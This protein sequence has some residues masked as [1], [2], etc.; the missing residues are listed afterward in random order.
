MKKNKDVLFLCQFFYPE[1]ISSAQLPFDTAK[2]LA[3]AGYSVNA[4]CGFPKEYSDQKSEKKELVEGIEIER[5]HYLQLPRTN[6]F[7]RLINYFSFTSSV[8]LNFWKLK[9]FKMIIVYSNPPILP[10]IAVL[11]KKLFST[12]FIFI[13]YDVYPE[14]ALAT[15][16]LNEGGIIT[17][18]MRLLNKSIYKNVKKIVALSN[19][20]KEFLLKNRK[21]SE[22]DVVVIPNWHKDT[23]EQQQSSSIKSELFNNKLYSD[24]LVISYMGNMGIAQDMQTI[25][26]AM[27]RLK[28]ESR[29]QFLIAGHGNKKES[30]AAY[31]KN[32][33]IKN[34]EIFEYLQGTDFVAANQVSDCFIV[35][36]NQDST[37]L[38]VPSKT[39]SY[40]MAG[41]P[42]LSI[43]N[44]KSDISIELEKNNAGFAIEN[45]GVASF[46]KAVNE[47][48]EQPNL[49]N[50]MG[51]N[52]RQLY[53][54]NYTEEK[55]AK[56][57]TKLISQLIGDGSHVQR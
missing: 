21:I 24:K 46:V 51:Q 40:L 43:M 53:L 49:V 48:L 19:D 37:G 32:H 6:F 27:E 17:K 1:Y 33:Q 9:K 26:E 23:Y 57:Y 47:L 18:I 42:V 56:R 16:A 31:I 44:K 41:K 2:A 54:D 50:T 30:V 45:Q 20:M 3:K 11:A 14:L 52:A 25:L 28:D 5:L 29:V 10:I 35:S 36:L 13:S 22:T 12:E 4:L 55:A 39:Y 34:A 38:A 8:L 15:G 7:G